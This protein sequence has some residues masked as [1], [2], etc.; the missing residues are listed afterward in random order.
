MDANIKWYTN[1][2]DVIGIDCIFSDAGI[3]Y[4]ETDSIS[5]RVKAIN[6]GV[7]KLFVEFKTAAGTLTDS[8]E[9]AVFKALELESPKRIYSDAIIVPPNSRI[10]LKANLPNAK[11]QLAEAKQ[12]QLTV[13]ADGILETSEQIGRDLVI[14]TSDDQTL[15]IPI[16]TKNIHYILATLQAPT[17][18][19]KHPDTKIPMGMNI[20]FKISLHDNLGNEFSNSYTDRAIVVPRFGHVNNVQASLGNNLSLYLGLAREGSNMLSVALDEHVGVKYNEDFIKLAVS[21]SS[22]RYPTVK[23]FSMGDIICFESPLISA[24]SDAWHSSDESIVWVDKSTGVGRVKASASKTVETVTI[25]NGNVARGLIKYDLE[26]READSVEFYQSDE[27]FNERSFTAH[28][29]M[30]NHLQYDKISNVFARNRTLCAASLQ[31]VSKQL[32]DCKIRLLTPIEGNADKV[33]KWLNAVPTFDKQRGTYA[34]QIDAS[35]KT[36][37][38]DIVNIAKRDELQFELEATLINGVS[39]SRYIKM[40]PAL[41]VHP[42]ELQIEQIEQQQITISGADRIIQQAHVSSSHP[43]TFEI[44]SG[45]RSH[46]SK[47]FKVKLLR[48]VPSDEN[49]FVLINSPLTL[50]TIRIPIRSAHTAQKCS[51]QPFQS[52]SVITYNIISNLGLIIFML[53]IL[54]ATVWGEFFVLC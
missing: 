14:A 29:I 17:F 49:V 16:E 20:A 1:Q 15:L 2:P 51:N 9:L 28:L 34:C 4:D 11:F 10:D 50:Q 13:S 26:I 32:Y 48:S 39:A 3:E 18:T 33:L 6:P 47:Q 8:I 40:L 43:N 23:T 31:S 19:L 35:G 45:T 24:M 30:K 5:V 52:F 22:G 38:A 12:S 42:L 36:T 53:F 27:I 41:N 7:A 37:I 54:A 21:K 46:N 44:T 25:A